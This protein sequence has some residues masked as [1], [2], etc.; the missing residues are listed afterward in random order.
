MN[1]VERFRKYRKG[2]ILKFQNSGI[3]PYITRDISVQ[4]IDSSLKGTGPIYRT[5]QY[6]PSEDIIQ[7][8]K[9]KEGF[10][11]N[12]YKDA[13]GNWTIGYGFKETLNGINR[14]NI[15]SI[16]EEDADEKFRQE[17]L[18]QYANDLV[19]LTPN[20]DKLNQNQRDALLSYMYNFGQNNYRKSSSMMKALKDLNHDEVTKQMD[21]GYNDK[22]NPGLRTRRNEERNWYK[23]IKF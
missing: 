12:W 16:T 5:E 11:P 2:G 14:Q 23:G 20:V 3:F 10:R 7:Y 9:E 15:Q 22:K 1:V 19:R 17:Y 21:A 18:P 13:N 4:A 8:I 6:V